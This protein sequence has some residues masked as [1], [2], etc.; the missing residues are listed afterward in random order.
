M[1]NTPTPSVRRPLGIFLLVLA[2]GSTTLR[3]VEPVATAPATA[4]AAP[5]VAAAP[6]PGGDHFTGE[7]GGLRPK[8]EEKG[9]AFNLSLTSVYQHNAHGGA[10]THNAHDV[11]GSYDMELSLDTGGMGLWPGGLLYVFAEGGWN[12]GVSGDVGDLF[13]LN[14]NVVGDYAIQVSELWYEQSFLGEKVRVRAGKMYV[15]GD[16]D[17]NAYANDETAQFLNAGLVTTGNIPYPDYALGAQV[18]VHPCDW[19]Q[20]GAVVADAQADGRETGL[21]TTFH[22]S[23]DFFSMYEFALEPVFKTARG[24]LPGAYRLGMW[25]DPQRKDRF[26]NDLGGR[27]RTVP[28]KTDDVG[29]YLSFDQL[30]FKEVP[31]AAEDSQGLGLFLRYGFAHGDVNA[32]E[33]FWSLGAQYQGL[34]PTRDDDVLGFGVA[35]GILSEQLRKTGADPD[36]ET[37][38]ELYYNA[39]VFP[40][41]TVTPDFQWI[42]NPGGENGRDAFVAGMRVQM[43]F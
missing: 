26:F 4:D 43:S 5:E 2:T 17:N 14:F 10:N 31:A 16:F 27:R 19:F 7:W 33:N 25:Y 1:A 38:L 15:A 28:V 6:F 36:R 9:I 12:D 37:V 34:I 23:D 11:S 32:V 42:L 40:W 22:G 41:V 24:E 29:F 21:N 39:L 8:L 35:Q 3:A 18:I 13:G 20:V 30:V